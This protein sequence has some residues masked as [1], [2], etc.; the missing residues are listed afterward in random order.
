MIYSPVPIEIEATR[1][2]MAEEEAIMAEQEEEAMT[3]VAK[4]APVTAQ[5]PVRA[6][7]EKYIPKPYL[8]RALVAPD[9]NHPEGTKDGHQ[10]RQRSVLQQHVAFFDEN[11]DGVI[12]PWETYRGLRRLGFN[13]IVS[14][15]V[16]IGIT[17]GLSYPTMHSWIPSPLFPI[18]IDRIHRAKH[19]SDS[20]TIDTEGRFMSVNFESIFSKNARSRPDKLTL[21]EIWTMTND[22]RAPYD[23]FG[24]IASKGEWIL[25]YM[26]AKDDEGYLPREA[27]RGCFDGSLFEFIADQ[28]KKK[29]HAKQH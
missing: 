23:P 6:D 20:A 7:L 2:L 13:I 9:V 4:A 16:A 17:L 10:H 19:G 26:L 25:L 28:R 14:F 8:A 12:Y 1:S 21:R 24:W 18:Y 5:R 22:N 11:G 3:S 15:I 29:A 27:I